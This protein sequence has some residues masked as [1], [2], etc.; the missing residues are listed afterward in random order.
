MQYSTHSFDPSYLEQRRT[1]A[2]ARAAA[3]A[4]QEFEQIISPAVARAHANQ[5]LPVVAIVW[6]GTLHDPPTETTSPVQSLTLEQVRAGIPEEGITCFALYDL[7]RSQVASEKDMRA[8]ISLVQTAAVQDPET[9]YIF[10]K[11]K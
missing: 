8:F 11:L 1:A 5:D 3:R 10:P 6:R 9:G 2:A 7:F 4:A